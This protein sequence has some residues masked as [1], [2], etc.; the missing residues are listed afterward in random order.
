MDRSVVMDFIL[1]WGW[2]LVFCRLVMNQ[3][4]FGLGKLVPKFGE[5]VVCR[6][7][8]AGAVL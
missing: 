7:T 3:S 2:G 5:H 4:W 8:V 1:S 6:S